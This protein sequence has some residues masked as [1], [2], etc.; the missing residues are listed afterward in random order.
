[1]PTNNRIIL[2]KSSVLNKAPLASDLEYGELAV[3]YRDGRIY[4]KDSAN[5]IQYFERINTTDDLLEGGANLY[6]TEVRVNSDI[7]DRVDKSFVDNLGVD[8]ATLDGELPSYYLDY[9][10]FTNTPSI[11]DGD[12]IVNGG[13]GLSGSATFNANQSGNTTLT[14]NNTDRGSAQTIFKNVAVSGETPI[15]ADNN[16][17]TLTLISG[18]GISVATDAINKSITITNT[19]ITGNDFVDSVS[20]N[21][22][23]GVLTLGRTGALNDLTVD[24]DGR[25]LLQNAQAVDSDLLD[26]ED[27]TYYLNYFNFT[28]TPTI[29]DG[30]LTVTG[31]AGLTGSGTFTAN[32]TTNTGITLNHADTSSQP[33]VDNSGGIVIQ[34]ID[35]DEFGHITSIG[36]T[37]LDSLYVNVT[38]DQMTGTLT[39]TN[40]EYESP[41]TAHTISQSMLDSDT[42]SWDGDSGQLF[43]ITDSL[44]GT[45]FSVNDISGF[46][47]IEV[48]DDGTIRLAELSG[49][50]LIGTNADNSVDKVQVIGSISAT[51]FSGDGSSVTNVNADLLDGEDGT[52]Y[53]D[54][55]NFTNTP[56]IGDGTLTVDSGSGL[57]GS[58]TFDA[59]T[60]SN[61]TITLSHADTS[62]QSSV[63]NSDGN[64]IQD[65]TLDEFGHITSIGTT[66]LD[67]RYVN[68]TGDTLTGF[69]TLHADPTSP[70]HAANKRYVDEVAQGLSIKPS[71]YVATTGSLS[72]TYSTANNTL[73]ATANGAISVDSTSLSLGQTV[74]VKDQSNVYENGSYE[75][76]QVGD[77]SNPWILTRASFMDETDEIGGAFEFVENGATNSSTGWVAT[78]PSD[79]ILNDT[80]AS[81]DPDF[82]TKGDI[83]WVQ[84][85][86]AGTFSAGAGIDL[87]GTEFSHA[88]TS[89]VSDLSATT[90]TFIDSIEFDT[91]GH[92]TGYTTS[93]SVSAND[94]TVTISAGAGLSTGGSF[95]TNQASNSTITIDHA[96]TSSQSSSVNTGRTYVQSVEVDTYGHV[97]A[98]STAEETVVDTNDFVSSVSFDIGTGDLTLTRTDSV[99]VS[100]NLD[101]RYLTN[102]SD[103]LDSVTGRGNTTTNSVSVGDVT[104]NTDYSLDSATST[105]STTT[106]TSIAEFSASAYGSAKVI[107]QITDTI[108]GE[109]QISE[110][111]IVHDGTDAYATEYGVVFTSASPLTTFDVDID[112]GNVR[113]LATAASSNTTDY[114][115]AQTL[116]I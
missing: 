19:E 12:F 10:N 1:M 82:T 96:D 47:S 32:A 36:S 112:S 41:N 22:S 114:T 107:A 89:S 94:S 52:Y 43:S 85:S 71:D 28:N 61:N 90:D 77:A 83:V 100:D 111:L 58:G 69:L 46:P 110:F 56:T 37:N 7:D 55:S 3:N 51:S 87:T 24:L 21:T 59:N 109:R 16:D 50:I 79:F 93:T 103:T 108:T 53:L 30:T 26:G 116:I 78:V 39:V 74:L 57:S 66:D 76:T 25:F 13:T 84:F 92:V 70:L 33:S 102:E 40:V 64:V 20:F 17:D 49:N 113:L 72:A 105:L 44:T 80:S 35:V 31:G 68:L 11:G 27:G 104:V 81:V 73:T 18:A 54:Y 2:K 4:Y 101:G 99:T 15:I 106:E 38:G 60:T 115:V 42:L 63:D 65:I 23:D 34:D 8:S 9:P 45:I 75:V 86:G 98:L 29:G 88:D 14:L 67:T 95:T 6:Y 62:S 91:Y 97:T 5:A 48:D